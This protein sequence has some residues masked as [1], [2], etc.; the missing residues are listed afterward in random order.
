MQ[1]FYMDYDKAIVKIPIKITR[2]TQWKVGVFF[3]FFVSQMLLS[4]IK[5]K[6]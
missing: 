5:D 3:V 1:I 6:T 4:Q 2:M